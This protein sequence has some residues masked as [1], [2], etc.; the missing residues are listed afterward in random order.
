MG[1]SR[2]EE[3]GGGGGRTQNGSWLV[4]FVDQGLVLRL[5]S[6]LDLFLDEVSLYHNSILISPPCQNIHHASLSESLL[7]KYQQK[8]MFNAECPFRRSHMTC[9]DFRTLY[10][11]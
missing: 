2:G 10:S 3:E 7:L 4:R 9:A 5:V 11:V 8:T 1:K 6:L